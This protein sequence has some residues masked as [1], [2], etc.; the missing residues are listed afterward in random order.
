[1]GDKKKHQDLPICGSEHTLFLCRK[2]LGTLVVVLF[3]S[4][5]PYSWFWGVPWPLW[6]W[7][8][9]E[10]S[11]AS[12]PRGKVSVSR[13][14]FKP[15]S[16]KGSMDCKPLENGL[17]SSPHPPPT[18]RG[19]SNSLKRHERESMNLRISEPTPS[20]SLVS[21]KKHVNIVV[22]IPNLGFCEEASEE[23]EQCPWRLAW[24]G[25]FT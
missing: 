7:T 16:C 22:T 11:W 12:S 5:Q 4:S 25:G 6:E 9:E 23:N 13:P 1:M 18:S 21:G 20:P 8:F 14:G 24:M 19:K 2:H 17:P 3:H 15:K 10:S